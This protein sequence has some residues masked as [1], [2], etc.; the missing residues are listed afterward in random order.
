MAKGRINGEWGLFFPSAPA[1]KLPARLVAI[2]SR[3][4]AHHFPAHRFPVHRSPTHRRPT[5]RFQPTAA[6]PTA[7]NP[8]PPNPLPSQPAAVLTPYPCPFPPPERHR[9]RRVPPSSGPAGDDLATAREAATPKDGQPGVDG[10]EQAA[11]G[12]ING[13]W[14]H[15]FSSAPPAKPPRAPCR[16]SKSV[17]AQPTVPQP[18]A[19]PTR[20]RLTHRRPNPPLS[21]PP[22][23]QSPRRPW[24]RRPWPRRPHP[25]PLSFSP[26][27]PSATARPAIVWP[28]G[29]RHQPQRGK[30]PSNRQPAGR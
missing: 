29:G 20:R 4:P 10:E 12:R 28:C 21:N 7:S 9:P 24:P 1:V 3:F 18:T 14:G 16:L 26:R 13:E 25:L 6:Q 8:S 11:K 19:V 17:A 27:T 30:R 23:V 5:H 2:Q 15:F 22:A